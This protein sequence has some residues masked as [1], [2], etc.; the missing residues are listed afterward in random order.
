L[1]TVASGHG[2]TRRARE[3]LPAVVDD[4]DLDAKTIILQAR[5]GLEPFADLVNT[6]ALRIARGLDT[7]VQ[8]LDPS[9]VVLGGGLMA[10]RWFFD[11]TRSASQRL[12]A[13]RRTE[14]PAL[15][16]AALGPW[17]VIAGLHRLVTPADDDLST[18]AVDPEASP[19]RGLSL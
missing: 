5:T 10:S 6:A 15:A 19:S 7:I 4:A 2:L 13:T 14:A 11:L 18:F 3:F 16:P 17:S 1:E 9:V 12:L 8:V